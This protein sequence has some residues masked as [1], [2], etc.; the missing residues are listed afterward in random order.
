MQ[1]RMFASFR[2]TLL[3]SLS[4][5]WECAHVPAIL[6]KSLGREH[7]KDWALPSRRWLSALTPWLIWA[8]WLGLGWTTKA[9]AVI[10]S[11]PALLVALLHSHA[12]RTSPVNAV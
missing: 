9:S 7:Q 6:C 5:S 10:G 1:R 4:L 8:A 11:S 12:C 2:P 3:T